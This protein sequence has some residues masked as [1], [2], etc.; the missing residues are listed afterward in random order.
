MVSSP[1]EFVMVTVW[2]DMEALRAFAGDD[3]K[4]SVIPESERPLLE[5]SLVHHYEVID[6][7]ISR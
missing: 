6:S 3:W 4:A 1:D 7:S 5:V 2:K